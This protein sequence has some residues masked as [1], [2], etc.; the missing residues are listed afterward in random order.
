MP[1]QSY[2]SS[3]D[4]MALTFKRLSALC[5]NSRLI[6]YYVTGKLVRTK[7]HAWKHIIVD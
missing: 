3:Y 2:I 4:K 7:W 5:T 6:F 1:I